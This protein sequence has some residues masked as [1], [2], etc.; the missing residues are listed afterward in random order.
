M[1][2][3][4]RDCRGAGKEAYS[5][6]QRTEVRKGDGS[7][8]ATHHLC[9][10]RKTAETAGVRNRS[11]R[12]T[13]E[14][15]REGVRRRA[16]FSRR[17]RKAAGRED[18]RPHQGTYRRNEEGREEVHE[19]ENRREESR[20]GESRREDSPGQREGGRG[21]RED[22][23]HRRMDLLD[24]R[25]ENRKHHDDQ[26]YVG[27]ALLYRRRIL[28]CQTLL[29]CHRDRNNPLSDRKYLRARRN[30]P[31]QIRSDSLWHRGRCV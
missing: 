16:K 5:R 30:H 8:P 21:R 1:V 6:G 27:R 19:E 14:E 12:S 20:H 11:G 23:L 3:A 26:V 31:Y 9:P 13:T 25:G 17:D 28:L 18:V 29:L 15:G 22:G 24:I 4:Q 2:A 10:D 7:P